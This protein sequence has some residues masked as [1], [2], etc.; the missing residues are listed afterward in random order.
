[1]ISFKSDFGKVVKKGEQ[2]DGRTS[3]RTDICT[4]ISAEPLAADK[5]CGSSSN[6]TKFGHTYTHTHTHTHTQ[7]VDRTVASLAKKYYRRR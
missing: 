7:K 5:N 6:L 4:S 2:T 1:M 3:G